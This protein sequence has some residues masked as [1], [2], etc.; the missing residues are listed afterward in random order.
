MLDPADASVVVCTRFMGIA[1]TVRMALRGMNVRNVALAANREQLLEAFENTEPDCLVLYV[2]NEKPDDE[3]LRFLN[4]IRRDEN[5]PN[6]RIPVVVLSPSREIPTIN[7]VMNAGA[8]G[9][10]LFPASG[11]IL[12]RK[13]TAAYTSRRAWIDRPDYVG[14]E[15]KID[16]EAA[17]AL[18][19]GEKTAV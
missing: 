2:D 13:I 3:G 4:F 14:P 16:R 17:E 9:Y 12:L 15:R 19:A 7:A 10:V 6:P 8:H 5:S 1:R 18:E 11:D